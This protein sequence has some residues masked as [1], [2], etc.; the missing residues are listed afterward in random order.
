MSYHSLPKDRR[1]VLVS[2]LRSPFQKLCTGYTDLEAYELGAYV[3]KSLL[4]KLNLR[5]SFI[6]SL[7]FS[8]TIHKMTTSNI[9]REVCLT[10]GLPPKTTAYTVSSG[11]SSAGIAISQALSHIVLGKCQAV[12]AGGTDCASDAPLGYKKGMRTKLLKAKGNKNFKDHVKTVLSLRPKDF[13]PDI[14]DVRELTT[15]V[16]MGEFSESLADLYHVGREEQ[17]RYAKRS[18]E[19]ALKAEKMGYFDEERCEVRLDDGHVVKE[20]NGVRSQKELENLSKLK[21]AFRKGGS[22]TPGNASFITDGAAA[23]LIM[24]EFLAEKL[25]LPILGRFVD[26][27]F[28]AHDPKTDLLLG[29]VYASHKILNDNKINIDET[30]VFEFHEPFA[31]QILAVQKCFDSEKF[32]A[33][34]LP[35]G[36]KIGHL[37]LE[38][39]NS[40]GGALSIGNPFAPNVARLVT[41]ACHRLQQEKGKRALI[42]TCSGGAFGHAILMEPG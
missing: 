12:I 41:T 24:S 4:E 34:N 8:T 19:L 10:A 35:G 15:G 2:G 1:P 18:H 27:V 31:S 17:D 36:Q 38:K 29:P 40:W 28:T 26:D 9:A 21:P 11:G 14:P 30:D 23:V 25:G 13:L 5:P 39:L 6:D 32:A 37:P 42:A 16:T 22:V 3:V 33:E 7:I 20:D